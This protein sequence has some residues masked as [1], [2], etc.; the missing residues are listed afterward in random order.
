MCL[1]LLALGMCMVALLAPSLAHA[2][3][4]EQ[5]TMVA[6][7]SAS[8]IRF[9]AQTS[10]GRRVSLN[11]VLYGP[12]NKR[13][14]PA[15]VVLPGSQGLVV[16]YCYGAIAR[17]FA[18]LGIVSL[19]VAPTT[20]RDQKGSRFLDYS[21]SDLARYADGAAGALAGSDQVDGNRI[22][23]WGHSRGGLAVI[24]AITAGTPGKF[25]FVAA[26]AIA[27]ICPARAK[28]PRVP[29]LLMIG[30]KD[31]DVSVNSCVRF[32]EMQSNVSTFDFQLLPK[33]GHSYW[34]PGTRDYVAA[35]AELAT[36]RLKKFLAKHQLHP[37]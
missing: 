9:D 26:V 6:N 15:L 24:E 5:C 33:A 16:P 34:A 22:G 31:T 37:P 2:V 18:D 28:Q 19:I 30:E 17:Q 23:L 27:P 13:K 8:V 12:L 7:G 3:N 1:R 21:F 36:T 20:A 32:A 10:D 25:S 4:V 29:I 14:S 11:G 35:S